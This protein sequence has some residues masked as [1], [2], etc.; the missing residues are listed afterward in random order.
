MQEEERYHSTR[1]IQGQ[2]GWLK[3]H[4]QARKANFGRD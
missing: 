2:T 3:L 1:E 4:G